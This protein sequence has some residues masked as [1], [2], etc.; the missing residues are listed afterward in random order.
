MQRDR[1]YDTIDRQEEESTMATIICPHCGKEVNDINSFCVQCG[2]PLRQVPNVIAKKRSNRF[3]KIVIA[4][5]ICVILASMAFI[6]W[7]LIFN[8]PQFYISKGD[9]QKAYDIADDTE[10]E[11]IK[12]ENLVAVAAATT[13]INLKN[14]DSFRLSYAWYNP[15]AILY[16]ST[17]GLPG[18]ILEDDFPDSITA[19]GPFIV[20]SYQGTNSYN[21]V[22]TTHSLY[23]YDKD[24]KMVKHAYDSTNF[25]VPTLNPFDESYKTDLIVQDI[26]LSIFKQTGQNQ[27]KI[28]DQSIQ[29]INNLHDK[30]LLSSVSLIIE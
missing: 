10:K 19:T 25:D 15:D 28:S 5:S 3:S 14:P 24:S 29:N 26:Y 30:G 6:A 18:M 9:Y 13:E 2:A 23:T 17:Q 12:K 4:V 7:I 11:D 8:N 27:Y 21:A 22:S 16:D 20:M 1:K